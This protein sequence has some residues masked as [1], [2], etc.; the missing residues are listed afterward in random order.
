MTS[1]VGAVPFPTL[2]SGFFAMAAG[3][4]A[5]TV[6][7]VPA[8]LVAEPAIVVGTPA[9]VE[10]GDSSLPQLQGREINTRITRT[11]AP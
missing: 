6:V 4:L 9:A 2:N 8:T 7:V 11:A 5:T 1:F 3:R 10:S